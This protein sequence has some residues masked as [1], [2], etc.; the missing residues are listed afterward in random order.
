[1]MGFSVMM[2][3]SLAHVKPNREPDPP[4][5]FRSDVETQIQ[6]LSIKHWKIVTT[7]FFEML[8]EICFGEVVI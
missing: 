1:M 6:K 7:K 8:L 2:P 5:D 3:R 4:I